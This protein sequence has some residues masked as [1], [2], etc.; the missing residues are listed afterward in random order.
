VAAAQQMLG[1]AYFNK[2]FSGLK[3]IKDEQHILER[4]LNLP[5]RF[6][7]LKIGI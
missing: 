1:C 2:R 3:K 4:L 6:A 7:R 5:S